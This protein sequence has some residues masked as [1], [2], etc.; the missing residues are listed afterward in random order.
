[1]AAVV[2]VI[3]IVIFVNI[4]AV[5]KNLTCSNVAIYHFNESA[6]TNPVADSKMD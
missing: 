5:C 6:S 2:V 4:V 3:V 1:M